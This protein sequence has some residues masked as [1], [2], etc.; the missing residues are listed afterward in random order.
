MKKIVKKLLVKSA[1]VFTTKLLYKKVTGQ[2]LNL[3]EPYNFNEKVQWLKLYWQHPKVIM[4]ADKYAVRE[5]I[6]C[7]N[8]SEILN[9]IY[10]VYEDAREINWDILPNKFVLKT[11]NASMTNIICLDKKK[12]D[13]ENAIKK[14]NQ[15]IKEDFSIQ[16][17]ELHYSMMKPKIICEKFIE[18]ENQA[19]PTDYKFFCFNG[20][21]KFFRKIEGRNPNDLKSGIVKTYYDLQGNILSL[22]KNE[23]LNGS[24]ENDYLNMDKIKQMVD[25]S[26]ILSKEFPFV[27]IDFYEG[28]LYPILGEMTFTPHM[29]MA[30]NYREDILEE[31]GSYINLPEKL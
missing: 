1:P 29:G 24:L 25:Y 8:S 21:P 6:N 5:Y 18:I 19:I 30:T 14:L 2:K 4:C 11:N 13:K 7:L 26:R 9:E 20:E 16:H 3:K 17:V 23:E 12:F 22:E 10:G 28:E 27:R 15:W 31:L